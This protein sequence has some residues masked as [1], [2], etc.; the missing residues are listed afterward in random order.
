MDLEIK[1]DIVVLSTA[2]WD[3][4]FWTNK[5]HV[6]LTLAKRGH[7]VLYIESLGLRR[8]SVNKKDIKRIMSR[9]VK[10]SKPPRKVRENIW[11]WSPISIPFNKYA[12][13]RKLNKF[14]LSCLLS[15]WCKKLA[16]K[17]TMLWTYNPLTSNFLNIDKF[18]YTVYHCVDEIKAQPGMPVSILESAE[19]AL[20]KGVD[21][22]FVTSPTLFESRKKWSNNV[23]YFSN[24]ADYNHFSQ[25]LD[26]NL[27]IPDDMRK[28]K[29]PIL[30]FIGAISSY[31]VNFDLLVAIAKSHPEWTLV[32]IGDVGEGDPSTDVSRLKELDN[33]K[34]IGPRPYQ[35]LPN[36]LKAFDVALLPNNINEY[37]ASM[38]P[39]K[40]FEYLAAGRNIV[41]VDLVSIREFSEYIMITTSNEGFIQAIENIL[42]GKAPSLSKIQELAKHYTYEARTEKMFEII[43]RYRQ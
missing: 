2:D 37:T 9:L 30:G 26:E 3:N 32:M 15:F 41:S 17:E 10:A 25:A 36:Y 24:V 34:I 14:L 4:P 38:F 20:T 16:F 35:E 31:K 21:I 43:N 1:K 8:P 42:D 12:I 33:I 7:R 22:V 23:H 39:M 40:F 13:I 5:Q 28:Y 11:V 18:S 29:T 6:A 27:A 19:E